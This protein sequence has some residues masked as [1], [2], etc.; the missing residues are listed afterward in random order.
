MRVLLQI[1]ATLVLALR[2][3]VLCCVALRCVVLC[4]VVLCCVVLRCIALCFVVLCCV[5]LCCVALCCIAFRCIFLPSVV[6]TV[7]TFRVYSCSRFSDEASVEIPSTSDLE[8]FKIDVDYVETMRG[9][10]F[11]NKGLVALGQENERHGNPNIPKVRN[12]F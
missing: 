7:F 8:P 6:I 2:C 9:S 1:N 11:I 5:V 12:S 4:C 10:S 3:V